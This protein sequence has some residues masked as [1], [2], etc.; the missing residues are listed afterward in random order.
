MHDTNQ[1]KAF[2]ISQLSN[3]AVN[4]KA[5]KFNVNMKGQPDNIITSET[6]ARNTPTKPSNNMP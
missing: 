5:H 1:S 2:D 4:D 6:F 3:I